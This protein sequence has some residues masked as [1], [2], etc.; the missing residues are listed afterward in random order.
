MKITDAYFTDALQRFAD[1]HGKT[2]KSKLWDKWLSGQDAY[3]V[4]G[5]I[6][7]QVRNHPMR[8]EVLAM[9]TPNRSR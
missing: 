1:N 2:W 9:I 4:D 6:L 5:S 3:M 7:R 8:D